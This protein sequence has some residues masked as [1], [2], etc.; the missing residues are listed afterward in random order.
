MVQIQ[1]KRPLHLF[2]GYGV[3]LEYMIVDRDT[4]NVLP[5]TDKVL[6]KIA[7]EIN[8]EISHGALALSNELVLHVI[9]IKTDGPAV[10]Y[11][12]LSGGFQAEVSDIN[13]LL[14]DFNA[15]LMPGA[16][17]PWM[18]PFTEMKLWPHEYNPIYEAYNRIFDC[19]GH[20]WANLQ[21]THLNLPFHGDEEFEKLCAALRILTP[22]LPALSA[23]SPIADGEKKSFLNF[24]MEVYNNNSTRIP[25]VA[26]L[27]I[28]E[29]IF[30][31]DDYYKH[32]FNPMY[33]DIA[34]FDQEG[35]L[36]EEWLNSRG[37]MA[38]FDRGAIEV[39]VMDIQ[40]C[41][42][43]DIAI[44]ALFTAVT[45]AL[46]EERWSKRSEQKKWHEK[47][48][49]EI[50]MNVVKN[51]DQAK[52][53]NR[54]FIQLFGINSSEMEAGSLWQHLYNEIKDSDLIDQEMKET[55]DVIIQHGPLGRRILDALPGNFSQ[56]ELK[57][58]Y[59][60]LCDCLGNGEMFLP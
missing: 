36:Q 60:K 30:S 50:L 33:R 25:S 32:I 55:L 9:E 38:R 13:N 2:D 35:T 51:G 15:M 34:P 59:R 43:A 39:R 14:K 1:E 17:H 3:E 40:E 8:S 41:P 45:Q 7:G 12:G 22:L 53:T 6:E 47:D 54:E 10:N 19:R 5:I 24:R 18:D 27:I 44:L 52:I 37:V 23:C 20:G 57:M 29:A 4:L 31:K 26:G 48:L 46:M 58:V 56:N 28:P 21:S 16:M 11:Q 49:Y 42:K